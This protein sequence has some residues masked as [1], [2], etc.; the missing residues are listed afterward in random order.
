MPEFKIKSIE[1]TA[2]SR[3]GGESGREQLINVT[4]TSSE[5]AAGVELMTRYGYNDRGIQKYDLKAGENHLEFYAHEH[6]IPWYLTFFV[7]YNKTPFSVT[8]CRVDPPSLMKGAE[9]V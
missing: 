1:P 7:Y 5:D 3:E 6:E 8:E 4:V 2:F 9:K